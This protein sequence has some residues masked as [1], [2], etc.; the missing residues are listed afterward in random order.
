MQFSLG[1]VIKYQSAKMYDLYVHWCI[2]YY[3][4]VQYI[5]EQNSIAVPYNIEVPRVQ[6]GI[7]VPYSIA[8]A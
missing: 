4:G 7:A 6:S 1:T 2:V 3:R 5:A 8:V